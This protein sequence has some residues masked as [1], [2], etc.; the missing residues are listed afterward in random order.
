MYRK[1][2]EL[3]LPASLIFI[4]PR[5]SHTAIH[6]V[7]LGIIRY[8]NCWEDAACLTAAFAP[9]RRGRFL[10]IASGGDNSFALLTLDPEEVALADV[11]PVQL[12]LVE[13]KMAAIRTLERDALLAF[14]GFRPATAAQRRAWYQS[15]A[16]TLPAG[17]KACW[18]TRQDVLEAGI[19]HAGRLERYFR[20]F[21]TRILPLIHNG[22]T[23]AQMLAPKSAAD[24]AA[25]F[26]HQWDTWRW[27]TL[28]R[29]FFSR[30]VMGWLGRDPALLREAG[31]H[32]GPRILARAARHLRSVQ[33]QDNA[34]LAYLSQ[35][36]WGQALPPWLHEDVLPVVRERLDRIRLHQ[37]LIQDVPS[38]MPFD[39]ANLSDI[40]EYMAPGDFAACAR[41][42]HARMRPGGRVAYWNLLVSRRMSEACP[43]LFRYEAAL[44][45]QLHGQDRCFFYSGM[46]VDEV[47]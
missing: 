8:A 33:V 30:Q 47:R 4:I 20:M 25:F 46:H 3:A 22:S 45:Q 36:Q 14:L 12:H 24:Q 31:D 2:R 17:T 42:I 37:C 39:G 10:S 40:F 44:S 29:L 26:D 18:D 43:D 9:L 19:T 27:R 23:V 32:V 1:K 13:L 6:E 34:Y 5:M 15:F 16:A 28:F 7:D 38:A 41:A 21:A 11:N 35:G